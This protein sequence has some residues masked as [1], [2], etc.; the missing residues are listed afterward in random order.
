MT[1]NSY[2]LSD[3]FGY[4]THNEINGIK[5]LVNM[6]SESNP[7]VINIG[8]G[9]GTSGISILEAREDSHLITLDMRIDSPLGSL[10]SEINALEKSG[11]GDI[12]D[13][14]SQV[15]GNS[16][17]LADMFDNET[18]HMVFIDGDHERNGVRADISAFLPKITRGGIIAFHDYGIRADGIE[19]WPEVKIAVDELIRPQYEWLVHM[20]TVIGFRV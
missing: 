3:S 15:L 19:P 9:A 20:D 13:R 18:I 10:Q 11:L 8:A 14:H 5:Q 2:Q 1:E 4:L 6:V 12:S 16:S 17:E 7:Q